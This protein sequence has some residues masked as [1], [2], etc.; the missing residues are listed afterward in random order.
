MHMKKLRITLVGAVSLAVAAC[1]GQGDDAL[2]ENVQENLEAQ[3]DNL[4]ALADNASGAEA[5]ALGNQADELREQGERA[6]EAI[7]DAD[8]NA[9]EVDAAVNGM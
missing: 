4:D 7:D 5:E 3:A 9:A 2:G 8:V 1:G 6:E